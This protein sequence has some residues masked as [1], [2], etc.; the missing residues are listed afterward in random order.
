V[1][2]SHCLH[3][4]E[5]GSDG[6]KKV[7]RAHRSNFQTDGNFR[8]LVKYHE[9][10]LD[11]SICSPKLKQF[12]GQQTNNKYLIFKMKYL[13]IWKD[14]KWGEEKHCTTDMINRTKQM[15]LSSGSGHM[16]ASPKL[17]L[18]RRR[19]LSDRPA[20]LRRPE[21]NQLPGIHGGRRR[22]QR[23][24]RPCSALNS[25]RHH[26]DRE[27]MVISLGIFFPCSLRT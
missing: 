11:D 24:R 8:V 17:I 18:H 3:S 23:V 1:D 20:R 4:L 9:H 5:E 10:H 19:S 6:Q 22:Y 12:S 2:R 14:V 15:C 27:R 13:K 16:A 26:P 25:C 7:L 21:S